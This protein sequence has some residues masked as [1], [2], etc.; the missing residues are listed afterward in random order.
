MRRNPNPC[1]TQWILE[2]SPLLDCVQNVD[3]HVIAGITPYHG[4]CKKSD[5]T[6][7]QLCVY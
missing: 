6:Q 2:I 4:D 7:Y 1:F 5:L 3:S